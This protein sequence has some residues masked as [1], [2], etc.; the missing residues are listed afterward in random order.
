M[1]AKNYI[2]TFKLP[3]SKKD[4]KLIKNTKEEL[5]D[6]LPYKVKFRKCFR[7]PREPNQY[8]GRQAST[9]KKNA[10]SF[11]LYYIKPFHRKR[12]AKFT[13]VVDVLEEYA[14]MDNKL[15]CDALLEKLQYKEDNLWDNQAKACGSFKILSV[16]YSGDV[17]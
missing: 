13:I 1:R 2:G 10:H 11:D 7:G 16:N 6:I 4:A 15:F 8:G 9:C 5:H 17:R 12:K 14:P 3:L